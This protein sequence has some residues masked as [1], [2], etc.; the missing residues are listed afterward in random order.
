MTLSEYAATVIG[1]GQGDND[2][3]S[4][5]EN[6]APPPY[7]FAESKPLGSEGLMDIF[8]EVFLRRFLKFPKQY[9]RID[10]QLFHSKYFMLL[11][12]LLH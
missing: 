3:S 4:S 2:C 12:L 1:D 7:I 10:S 8:P 6:E 9:L 11:R 5:P